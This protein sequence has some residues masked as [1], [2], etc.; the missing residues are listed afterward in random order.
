M[1]LP[2][3]RPPDS[4]I[5]PTLGFPAFQVDASVQDFSTALAKQLSDLHITVLHMHMADSALSGRAGDAIDGAL[6][7]PAWD[8]PRSAICVAENGA[9]RL[10]WDS[11]KPFSEPVP[12]SAFRT[13][14]PT[15]R[16]VEAESPLPH[17]PASS[18]GSQLSGGSP[19][20]QESPSSVAFRKRSLGLWSQDAQAC[21]QSLPMPVK[22][23]MPT[24][25][26]RRQV[27]RIDDFEDIVTQGYNRLKMRR[28][29]TPAL[30]EGER[31]S[32]TDWR[33]RFNSHIL[34]P[35][36]CVV[37]II[38]AIQI[39]VS[40]DIASDADW[41]AYVDFT[42]IGVYMLELVIKILL[43]GWKDFFSCP[44]VWFN[45][46][47]VV[48]IAL[49]LLG[50]VLTMAYTDSD[51]MSS[52]IVIVRLV[53]LARISR[54]MRLLRF[55]IFKELL[56]M[57]AG[58]VSGLRTLLW[59]FVLMFLAI[60]PMSLVLTQFLGQ[61]SS[62]EHDA[63]MRELFRSV[64][65][66]MLTVFRCVTG[67]CNYS[68][69][70]PLILALVEKYGPVWIPIYVVVM[71]IVT[72]GLFN[73]IM[74]IFVDNALSDAKRQER[75]LKLAKLKDRTMQKEKTAHL[76]EMLLDRIIEESILKGDTGESSRDLHDGLAEVTHMEV[77]KDVFTD[78]LLDPEVCAI[79]DALDVPEEERLDIFEVLDANGNG[80]L[81]LEELI[82]GV[83]KLRGEPRRSDTVHVLL[84]I[85]SLQEEMQTFRDTVLQ[86]MQVLRSSVEPLQIARI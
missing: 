13:S 67:D 81:Q 77:S 72:F 21:P 70:T 35:A 64:P 23:K 43:L 4:N 42:F 31:Y 36:I 9:P 63:Q 30:Q 17:L 26:S 7:P 65:R 44:Q 84:V 52:S 54:I 34:E 83:I 11:N 20:S 57:V 62:T 59:A 74:A 28:R 49:A 58:L 25:A 82:N 8:E 71:L 85:Q 38:N 69:G 55:S 3:H 75:E 32:E 33:K 80:T 76:L 2:Q 51:Q 6:S 79:L 46:F 78:F 24:T 48:I 14:N 40:M 16:V 29:N 68:D 19:G 47:D 60:Y 22:S 45:M 37:L 27:T 86:Q 18:F 66:S 50:A 53:R 10:R 56:T 5:T 39:G 41:W 61:D 15:H 73:L 12:G 1:Q